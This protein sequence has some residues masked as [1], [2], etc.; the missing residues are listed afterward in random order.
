ML[1]VGLT[2]GIGSGKTVVS[3][4]FEVL[5]VPVYNADLAAKILLH[6]SEALSEKVV[7]HFGPGI[8]QK[9][10]D[11]DRRKLGAIVFNDSAELSVLNSI[12]HPEVNKDFELWLEDKGSQAYVIKEAAILF[13]SGSYKQMDH[14]VSVYAGQE[15]RKQRV[16]DRDHVTEDQFM[17]REANQ[18]AEEEKCEKADYVIDNQG[19][20]PVLPQVLKIHEGII[21]KT[22]T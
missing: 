18:M 21:R 7:S 13:E 3:K 20:T 9:N 22:N 14:I 16:I 5:H 4:V 17:L 11:I 10:G 19:G 12:L 2:G 8:R 15:V 1:K 6:N